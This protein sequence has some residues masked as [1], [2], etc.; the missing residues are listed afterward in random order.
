[1]G[2]VL[3]FTAIDTYKRDKMPSMQEQDKCTLTTM[4]WQALMVDVRALCSQGK[5]R[6]AEELMRDRVKEASDASLAE[7][8]QRVLE[9]EVFREHLRI[10]GGK[11]GMR[12]RGC[13]PITVILPGGTRCK[14]NSPYFIKAQP[15]GRRKR[16][17]GPGKQPGRHLGLELLGFM[18]QTSP[19][20]AFRSLA[21]SALCPSFATASQ[22]LADE[23]ISLSA[24][25]LRKLA[26]TFDGLPA[27]QRAELSCGE[28]ESVAGKRVVI[29]VDGGRCRERQA[30]KGRIPN[31]NKRRGYDTEWREPKLFTIAILDDEGELDRAF[32]VQADASLNGL[33]G[34]LD[35]LR[36]YL[37]RLDI[38]NAREVILL[39][40]GA[41]WLWNHL[42]PL[43]AE[44]GVPAARIHEVL[45]H[46]HAKQNLHD[47]FAQLQACPWPHEEEKRRGDLL[48]LLWQGKIPELV[49]RLKAEAAKGC[50]R[51]VAK[52]AREYFL[53]NAHRLHYADFKARA[54]PRG[55]GIVESAIRRVINLRV[56]NAGSFWLLAKAE[57]MIF[58]R[59]KLLYGRWHHLI[60]SWKNELKT[61]FAA[62]SLNNDKE[63]SQ[64]SLK[65]AAA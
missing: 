5:W 9:D 42:P 33:E 16:K 3:G 32:P 50:K 2:I 14:V 21:L 31:G 64:L 59:A 11:L 51:A 35:L 53:A 19:S 52:K 36:A 7:E 13:H 17:R 61:A 22:V 54:I 45:D 34:L 37:T 6:E 30:K 49:D 25:K 62:I 39:G 23:G 48:E 29:A 26:A 56:K 46:T 18:E 10:L 1:M 43:L 60:A 28:D 27:E 20:L 58:L 65:Q 47:L 44:L 55:S 40:D 12:C 4:N 57:T 15:Q 8:L 38:A 24:D 41:K 63:T